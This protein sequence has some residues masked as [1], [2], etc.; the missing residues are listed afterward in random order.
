MD[1]VLKLK[2]EN[3]KVQ[4]IHSFPQPLLEN[5]EMLPHIRS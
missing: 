3:T 1:F 4:S 5:A 2:E